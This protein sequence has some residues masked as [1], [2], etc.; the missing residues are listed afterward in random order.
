MSSGAIIW[1]PNIGER[2]RH[3]RIAKLEG[4]QLGFGVA[5]NSFPFAHLWGMSWDGG[6]KSHVR[7]DSRV[8]PQISEMSFFG[9]PLCFPKLYCT[10]FFCMRSMPANGWDICGQ[11]TKAFQGVTSACFSFGNN[12][13]TTKH[14]QNALSLWSIIH[15]RSSYGIHDFRSQTFITGFS[16]MVQ[17]HPGSGRRCCAAA[18]CWKS[19]TLSSPPKWVPKEIDLVRKGTKGGIDRLN[20]FR[21]RELRSYPQVSKE[22]PVSNWE[23]YSC[24]QESWKVCELWF[25]RHNWHDLGA[26][27]LLPWLWE[28]E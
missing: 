13:E 27:S 9:M 4:C 2:C 17:W 10:L 7:D 22:L 28:K 11:V 26:C 18:T 3:G 24:F 25:W 6:K 8:F 15:S 21:K 20:P 14:V 23:C 19:C 5:L 12:D 16:E 1:G